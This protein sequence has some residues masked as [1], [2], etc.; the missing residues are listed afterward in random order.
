MA[1]KKKFTE[2]Q[3][4]AHVEALLLE[5]KTKGARTKKSMCQ[6]YHSA[7]PIMYQAL[8]ILKLIRGSWAKA[9]E[10]LLEGMDEA[11]PAPKTDA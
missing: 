7:R 2:K 9:L 1:L 6:L 4:D 11:C 10:G 8:G 5:S 3:I